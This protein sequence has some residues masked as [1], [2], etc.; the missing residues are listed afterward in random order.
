MASSKNNEDQKYT[1]FYKMV[2]LINSLSSA[3]ENM[4]FSTEKKYSRWIY[5]GGGKYL[6]SK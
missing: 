5:Q 4:Y 1:Y 6:S 2:Y 3:D